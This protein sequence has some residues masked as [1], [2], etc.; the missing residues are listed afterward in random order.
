M[1]ETKSRE[2]EKK[3]FYNNLMH[4]VKRKEEI[5]ETA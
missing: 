3:H 1:G 2:T 4:E 5:Q